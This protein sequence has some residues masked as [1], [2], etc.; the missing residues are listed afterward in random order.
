MNYTQS[1]HSSEE[2]QALTNLIIS[3][4]DLDRL[5]SMLSELNLFEAIGIIRQEL[6]HSTLLAFLLSPNEK[7]GLGD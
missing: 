6:K 2:G 7:H 4:P 3:N 1:A 5:E